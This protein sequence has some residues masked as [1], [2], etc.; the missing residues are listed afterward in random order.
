MEKKKAELIR[1]EVEM[2]K[3]EFYQAMEKIV[4]KLKKEIEEK[5]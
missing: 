5:K 2:K 3:A 4:P 1:K